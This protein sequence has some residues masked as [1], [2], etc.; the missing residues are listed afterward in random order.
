MSTKRPRKVKSV[1]KPRYELHI[2]QDLRPRTP[3]QQ[4]VCSAV[5]SSLLTIVNGPAGVG[6]TLLAA[7]LG[8]K[9]M[10]SGKVDKIVISRPVVEAGEKLGALPGDSDEKLRP[11][12]QPLY[13]EL[14]HFLSLSD[15]ALLKNQQKLEI[16]PLAFT[17]GRTLLNSFVILDEAQNATFEQLKM[18]ITRLGVGSRMIIT[19]D[20][21]Q[22]DLPYRLQGG[23]QKCID[24]LQNIDGLSIIKMDATDI[25]RSPILSEIIERL[26]N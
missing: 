6:K 2:K 10:A 14:G 16:L 4:E 21:T 19:G 13:D 22:S 15:M 20:V 18:F 12:L 11:Y 1:E 25:Q 9:Y 3:N 24:R 26:G 23:F 5:H 17:R 8:V 7:G